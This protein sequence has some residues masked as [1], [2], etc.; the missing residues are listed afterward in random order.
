[1]RLNRAGSALLF[2]QIC[3]AEHIWLYVAQPDMW[4]ARF[5]IDVRSVIVYEPGSRLPGNHWPLFAPVP[6]LIVETGVEAMTLAVLANRR[7]FFR[8]LFAHQGHDIA[9]SGTKTRLKGKR[10]KP[11]VNRNL[12]KSKQEAVAYLFGR[13]EARR[14]CGGG[15]EGCGLRCRSSTA[16]Q[17]LPTQKSGWSALGKPIHSPS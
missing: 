4:R 11:T 12:L 6:K 9:T 5:V 2:L 13:V 7:E 1:V 10:P 17:S 15:D 3:F 16:I 8:N 14:S